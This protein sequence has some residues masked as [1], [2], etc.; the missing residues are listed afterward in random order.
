MKLPN[1]YARFGFA[2]IGI[3]IALELLEWLVDLIIGDGDGVVQNAFIKYPLVIAQVICLL[4]ALLGFARSLKKDGDEKSGLLRVIGFNLALL[5]SLFVIVEVA[6]RLPSNDY[7]MNPK[8]I[9]SVFDVGY[10]ASFDSILGYVPRAGYTSEETNILED[11]LRSNGQEK[12]SGS[13]KVILAVGDSYTYGAEESD[14]E[15]WPSALE[16]LTGHD[17]RNAGVFGYGLDQAVIRAERMLGKVK[18]DILIVSF[19]NDDVVRCG[20]KKRTHSGKPYFKVSGTGLSLHT[21]QIV[22]EAPA[23]RSGIIKRTLSRS[24]VIH[25]LMSRVAPMFWYHNL[26]ESEISTGEDIDIIAKRL[27]DRIAARAAEENIEIVFLAQYTKYLMT[28]HT[29][30]L[31][32]YIKS[33]GYSLVDLR[34]ELSRIKSEDANEFT[35]LYIDHMTGKGNEF[36]A[37]QICSGL[38]WECK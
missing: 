3:A 25:D 13:S 35:S 21:D 29:G 30:P 15:S 33:K 32:E 22:E 23:E 16:R 19:I 26:T 31:V 6:Y 37:K 20:L 24:R 4:M 12:P 28:E 5:V 34:P 2:A 1:K 17:V 10:P 14:V 11:G 27:V 8:L 7:A 38:Q 9:S 18:P 36:V